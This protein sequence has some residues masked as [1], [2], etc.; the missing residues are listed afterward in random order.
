MKSSL[1][2][3]Y[4]THSLLNKT[5]LFLIVIF[6]NGCSS[7]NNLTGC[8]ELIKID[9]TEYL[10]S[11]LLDHTELKG[12]WIIEEIQ[13]SQV[14]DWLKNYYYKRYSDY[15]NSFDS[16]TAINLIDQSVNFDIGHWEKVEDNIYSLDNIY[17]YTTPEDYW[18]A[19]AGQDGLV[20]IRDCQIIY[21]L[22]LTVS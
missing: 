1:L 22:V 4:T 11:G 2:L 16:T 13:K 15:F 3:Y 9:S 5:I 19:L 17:Y 18:W 7:T 10:A 8:G 14:K 12:D 20:V 21:V 6:I